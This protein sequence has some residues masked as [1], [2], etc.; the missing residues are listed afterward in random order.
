MKNTGLKS[1]VLAKKEKNS[2][3]EKK[4]KKSEKNLCLEYTYLATSYFEN[5]PLGKLN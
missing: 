5:A 2:R 1:K 4:S 3:S